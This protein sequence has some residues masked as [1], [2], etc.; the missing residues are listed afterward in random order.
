MPEIIG[1]IMTIATILP[2]GRTI[3]IDSNGVPLV[4]GTVSFF[5]PNTDTPKNTW[6]NSAASVLNTNP[7]LLASDGGAYIYGSGQYRVVVKNSDGDTLSDSLTADTSYPLTLFEASLATQT[8]TTDGSALVGY[9]YPGGVDRTLYSKLKDTVS[10]KDFGAVGDGTTDDTAAIQTALDAWV[11]VGFNLHFPTGK[12]RITSALSITFTYTTVNSINRP[13]LTGDGSGNSQ[14]LWDGANSPST[15]MLT[16]Q[17]TESVDGQGLAAHS[18]IQ[19]IGFLPINSGKNQYVSG[20]KLAKWAYLAVRDVW[21]HRLNYGLWLDQVISTGFYD[22]DLR[23]NNYGLWGIGSPA[24]ALSDIYPLN[25][26]TFTNCVLGANILG[27]MFF[28]DGNFVYTGGTVEANG[29]G[30]TAGTGFGVKILTTSTS[31]SVVCNFVGTYIEANGTTGNAGANASTAD[32]WIVHNNT[33][34]NLSYNF[35]GCIFNRTS[36]LYAP[37]CIYIDRTYLSG[38]IL[39]IPGCNFQDYGGYTPSSS[40]PYVYIYNDGVASTGVTVND[41]GVYYNQSSELPAFANGTTYYEGLGYQ[42]GAVVYPS[43]QQSIPDTTTTAIVWSTSLYN[44]YSIWAIGNPTRLTVP[45]NVGYVRI[46]GNIRYAS[47][48]VDASDFVL[49]LQK[50]GSATFNGNPRVALQS[51]PTATRYEMQVVSPILPVTAGDYF[52]LCVSQATGGALN[53]DSTFTSQWFSME[54]IG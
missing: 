46:S 24:S 14:I 36:T 16:I 11:S 39:N 44:N 37:Y 32:I 1:K 3:Y 25:A 8:T 34:N 26:L 6:T 45:P 54:I 27:G 20:L 41:D 40:R 31:G 17:R 38:V 15:F 52:T 35:W 51:G 48:S 19:G 7:V 43:V 42:P 10:V 13:A 29:T 53:T 49:L 4:S 22:L 33:V 23:F 18:V 47:T 50:N 2:Q 30:G 5:V 21:C 28:E 12:Y 9:L